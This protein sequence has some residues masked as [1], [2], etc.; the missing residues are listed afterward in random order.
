MTELLKQL[1]LYAPAQGTLLSR[2]AELSRFT[3]AE[4]RFT[5]AD[6]AEELAQELALL[7]R[8]LLETAETEGWEGNLWQ[9]LLTRQ[10]LCTENPYS[11]ACEGRSDPGGSLSRLA[12]RELSLMRELFAWD[13]GGLRDLHGGAALEEL[14]DFQR[15]DRTEVP[16]GSLLG[17]YRDRLAAAGNDADFTALVSGFYREQGAGVFALDRAFRLSEQGALLPLRGL[18]C[19]PL[20]ALVGY[21]LQ[22]KQLRENTEAFLAGWEANNVLLYGD[23]GT[24]K[25][26]CVRALLREYAG[27]PLRMVEVR[28]SQF[29]LL[30]ELLERLRRRNYRFILFI[31]DLSFEEHE[32]EYKELKAV[33]EGGLS[34]LPQNLRIYATSNRRHI[35]R[36]L[37]SDR[38]DM[39]HDGD[40]H[41]SDTMEEKLSLAERFG[42]GINFSAPDRRLYH[43]IILELARRQ[44]P[45]M[46]E[47]SALLLGAD[48]WE[49]RHGGVSGRVAQQYIDHLAGK[50]AEQT[51]TK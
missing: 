28:K 41:R 24:G 39:E 13:F 27:S 26:T 31:D 14:L 8:W 16:S 19:A 18:S 9:M 15:G 22:K 38:S 1:A 35:V 21:E 6:R 42:I 50:A 51:G 20:S 29:R 46:P 7:L 3:R 34:P 5:Q 45:V 44:L 23:A 33:I 48:A 17:E 43:E 2:F 4:S 37:W 49:I 40:V 25:S 36:E 12:G 47:E 11:L 32:T 10:L 30:P